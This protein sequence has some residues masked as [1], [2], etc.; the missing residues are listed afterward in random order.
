MKNVKIAATLALC[1]VGV[2]FSYAQEKIKLNHDH[3]KMEMAQ[4]VPGFNDENIAN[5][6]EHYEHLKND[7]VNSNPGDAQ[8]AAVMLGEALEKIEGSD[9]ALAIS[10]NLAGSNDLKVQRKIFSQLNMPMESM[11]RKNLKSG[12]I[13]KAFCPM[14]LGNGAYWLSSIEPIRNPYYGAN[15]LSCGKVTEVIE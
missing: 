8:K 5:V 14:A 10:K 12:K 15:M 3:S 6:Y 9:E 13:Y 1:I 7:L 11:V 2:S 4:N